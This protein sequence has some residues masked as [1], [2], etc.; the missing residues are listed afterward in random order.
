MLQWMQ[1]RKS[2]PELG[3]GLTPKNFS[4]LELLFVCTMP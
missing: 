3:A 1:W 2:S 4:I